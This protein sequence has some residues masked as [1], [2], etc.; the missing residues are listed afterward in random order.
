MT[1]HPD[2]D[3]DRKGYKLRYRPDAKQRADSHRPRQHKQ[4][5]ANPQRG[6]E[7]HRVHRRV[8]SVVYPLPHS[9]QREAVVSRVGI[10]HPRRSHH[11]PL[12]H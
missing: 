7:Q 4:A 1:N 2:G 10:C 5:H 3:G 12:S 6:V 8:R 11:A 9:G